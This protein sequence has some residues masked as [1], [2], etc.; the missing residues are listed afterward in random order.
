LEA[1]LEEIEKAT[2]KRL[3]LGFNPDYIGSWFGR[4]VSDCAQLYYVVSILIIL[5]AGLEVTTKFI[6]TSCFSVS[7]LI[8]LEAGLE[9]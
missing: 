8:I 6:Y 7:I 9:A 5:E 2:G 4:W 3:E 1:G